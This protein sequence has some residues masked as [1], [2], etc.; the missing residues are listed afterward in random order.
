MAIVFFT[1]SIGLLVLGFLAW[2]FI[3]YQ[4]TIRDLQNPQNQNPALTML[5]Q[6]LESLRGQ[7]SE[8]LGRVHDQL[9][10]S[11]EALG[12]RLDRATQ[13][14]GDVQRR[15]G[16]LD[17]AT[18]Q[19]LDMGK[20]WTKE[21]GSLQSVFQPPKV[22]G[23]IGEMLLANLLKDVLASEHY[24]LQHRFQSGE[25]VDAVIKLPEGMVPVDAKFPLENFRRFLEEPEE[26][27]RS[28]LRKEFLRNVKKHIEDIS[29]KYIL[30]DEGTLDFAL[31]Y[32][33]AEN[34]YYEVILRDS[35]EGLDL[36]QFAIDRKVVPVSPNSFYAYLLALVRGF[37]GLKIAEKAQDILQ[38]L[39]RLY[40]DF[41]RFQDDFALIGQHLSNAQKKYAE[42]EKRLTRFEDKLVTLREGGEPLPHKKEQSLSLPLSQ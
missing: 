9:A 19:L 16:S 38:H 11:Q 31:M 3:S 6:Q 1:V 13:V 17:Q 12:V 20:D 5:Q 23:G 26:K 22:R 25:K 28:S 24:A 4:K 40:G 14:V 37:R 18:S 7:V 27:T 35:E 42:A 29:K 2:I 30:P 36:H 41:G 8:Q 21:I 15:L 33:P 39:E 10:Q 32:V 34:V